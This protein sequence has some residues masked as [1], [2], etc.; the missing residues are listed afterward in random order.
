M[1]LAGPDSL[2]AP[3]AQQYFWQQTEAHIKREL[4]AVVAQ[5]W[6]PAEPVNETRI[7]VRQFHGLDFGVHPLRVFFSGF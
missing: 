6:E 4:S 7:K 5:G 2:T 1:F 3:L